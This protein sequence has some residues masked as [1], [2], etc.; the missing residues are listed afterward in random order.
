MI[1]RMYIMTRQVNNIINSK[2]DANH[3]PNTF[4]RA[5]LPAHDWYK[6]YDIDDD[7]SN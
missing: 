4:T 6:C 7:K 1:C 5:Q 3:C 2:T